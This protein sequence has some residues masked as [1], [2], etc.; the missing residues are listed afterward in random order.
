[1]KSCSNCV[2]GPDGFT[3][4]C[5][6]LSPPVDWKNDGRN[7]ELFCSTKSNE[8]DTDTICAR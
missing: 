3:C 5:P 6:L 8:L 7:C 4:R 2:F 1:M